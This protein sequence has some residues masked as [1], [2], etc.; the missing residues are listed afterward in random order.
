MKVIFIGS[1]AVK[2]A[3]FLSFS[4]NLQIENVLKLPDIYKKVIL[5]PNQL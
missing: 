5:G 3:T 4:R 2:E 1:N